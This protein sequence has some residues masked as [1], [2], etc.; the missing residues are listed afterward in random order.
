L[1]LASEQGHLK[2]VKLLIAHDVNVNATDARGNTSYELAAKY[3][4]V[5]HLLLLSGRLN[6]ETKVV[7]REGER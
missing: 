1:C 2:V 4:G 5:Q 7:E 6:V 3:R